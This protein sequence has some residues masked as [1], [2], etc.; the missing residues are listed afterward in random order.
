MPWLF[1]SRRTDDFKSRIKRARDE[2]YLC[3]AREGKLFSLAVGSGFVREQALD[4]LNNVIEEGRA[5]LQDQHANE[6]EIEAW[7]MS[8]R[9]AFWLEVK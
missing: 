3:G 7:D 5:A 1:G 9:I 2:G 8:C 6:K 4:W